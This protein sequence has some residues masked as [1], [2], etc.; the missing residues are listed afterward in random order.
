MIC[1]AH[2]HTIG[3]ENRVCLL[4]DKPG[5][6]H[7]GPEVSNARLAVGTSA[8]AS[9]AD[10]SRADHTGQYK[11]DRRVALECAVAAYASV[12]GERS[13]L[14]HHVLTSLADQFLKWL[15]S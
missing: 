11:Q 5:H 15:R 12:Y 13:D 9:R 2:Y 6:E 7:C 1:G 3:G 14:S 10:Q 8:T 4:D